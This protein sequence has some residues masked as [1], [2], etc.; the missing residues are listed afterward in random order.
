MKK[1]T[2]KEKSAIQWKVLTG[3]SLAGLEKALE[4][5]SGRNWEVISILGP[6]NSGIAVV[7]RR[8]LVL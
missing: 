7:L 4:E 3:L 2:K 1:M 6:L 8:T 5:W